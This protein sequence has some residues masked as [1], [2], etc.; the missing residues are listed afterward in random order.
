M[1]GSNRRF[2][3]QQIVRQIA[4]ALLLGPA[5]DASYQDCVLAHD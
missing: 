1:S 5:L 4:A 2:T 3:V